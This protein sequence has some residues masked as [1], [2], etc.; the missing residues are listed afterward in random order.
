MIQPKS[1]YEPAPPKNLILKVER[2]T[3]A[4]A[5]QNERSFI[6]E[7]FKEYFRK[8]H[9]GERF[10]AE[11]YRKD[12]RAL[13]NGHLY[14]GWRDE[15]AITLDGKTVPRVIYLKGKE[16]FY[17]H[18]YLNTNLAK[19]KKIAR[20]KIYQY[21]QRNWNELKKTVFNDVDLNC[22]DIYNCPAFDEVM[23]D[24]MRDSFFFDYPRTERL[25]NGNYVFNLLD[26][27]FVEVNRQNLNSV[28]V[29]LGISYLNDRNKTESGSE[30]IRTDVEAGFPPPPS[31]SPTPSDTATSSNGE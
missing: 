7:T 10:H 16:D 15:A 14:Q 24:R 23:M 31:S 29:V 3:D 22:E 2:L 11:A 12:P 17:D 4:Q 8:A 5:Q 21:A 25:N 9:P 19:A 18:F 30:F 20:A 6:N 13:E 27:G 1:Y 28:H 26:V